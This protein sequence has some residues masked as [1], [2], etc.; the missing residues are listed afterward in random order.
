MST[1][2][3]SSPPADAHA[4]EL[5][6]ALSIQKE[7]KSKSGNGRVS[8]ARRECHAWLLEHPEETKGAFRDDFS[9]PAT[10]AIG[11]QTDISSFSIA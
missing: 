4:W 9:E 10:S 8:R 2:K 7:T 11:M 5:T 1:P 3:T 6:C